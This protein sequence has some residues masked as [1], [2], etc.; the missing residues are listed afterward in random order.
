M[1]SIRRLSSGLVWLMAV[2]LALVLIEAC[3]VALTP[4]GMRVRTV[5]EAERNR[6][7]LIDMIVVS[8]GMGLDVADKMRNGMK[9]AQNEVGA[10]G[11]NGMKVLSAQIAAPQNEAVVTVEALKCPTEKES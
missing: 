2:G 11:G 3:S 5:S 6:C 9:A 4:E 10:R 7:E 1:T 8:E